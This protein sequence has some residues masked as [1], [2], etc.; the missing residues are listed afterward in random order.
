MGIYERDGMG[1]ALSAALNQALARRQAAVERSAGYRNANVA[2]V[3]SLLKSL[4]YA[5]DDEDEARLKELKAERN[6]AEKA[7]EAAID[8]SM[9]RS[10][11]ALQARR[12][13]SPV[14][15]KTYMQPSGPLAGP[16]MQYDRAMGMQGYAPNSSITVPDYS[17]ILGKRGAY[18]GDPRQNR[19]DA[20]MDAMLGHGE[21]I[22]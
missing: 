10:A 19:I 6:A 1:S 7:S 2:A 12:M 21:G 15:P 16:G 11:E 8:E 17:M 13:A 22:Y 14:G 9:L 3:N 4:A 18:H 20:Y 5:G